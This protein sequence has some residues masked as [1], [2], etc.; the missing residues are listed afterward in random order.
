MTIRLIIKINYMNSMIAGLY[1]II[2]PY[3]TVIHEAEVPGLNRGNAFCIPVFIAYAYFR[4][5]RGDCLP[6]FI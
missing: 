6:G 3:T 1:G 5:I 4:H 2:V